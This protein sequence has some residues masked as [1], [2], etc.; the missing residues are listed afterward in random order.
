MRPHGTDLTSRFGPLAAYLAMKP[1]SGSLLSICIHISQ[2]SRFRF[3]VFTRSLRNSPSPLRTSTVLH[4]YLRILYSKLLSDFTTA[5]NLWHDSLNM[6]VNSNYRAILEKICSLSFA[7]SLRPDLCHELSIVLLN[8]H[9]L[10][11]ETMD[12]TPCNLCPS[13]HLVLAFTAW[14]RHVVYLRDC[15]TGGRHRLKTCYAGVQGPSIGCM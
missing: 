15:W 13:S 12:H 4:D 8:F 5:S 14:A 2:L 10:L 1:S 11:L 9:N 6:A 3:A 7:A